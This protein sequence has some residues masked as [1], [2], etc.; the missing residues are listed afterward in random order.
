[1]LN[2]CSK[3]IKGTQLEVG[4]KIKYVSNKV[5]FQINYKNYSKEF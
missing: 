4:L 2:I 1:M 3:G 5:I